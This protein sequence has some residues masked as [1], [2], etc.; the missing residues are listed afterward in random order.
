VTFHP[1]GPGWQQ[2]F[3]S[4]FG[5]VDGF[6]WPKGPGKLRGRREDAVLMPVSLSPFGSPSAAGAHGREEVHESERLRQT[7]DD[8]EAF[9]GEERGVLGKGRDDEHGDVPKPGGTLKDPQDFRAVHLGHAKVEHNEVGDHGAHEPQGLAAVSRRQDLVSDI[10][11]GVGPQ[12]T[13]GR[14]VI[15]DENRLRGGHKCSG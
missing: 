15:D 7:P 14:V 6:M 2:F 3:E 12:L 11:E 4:H 10:G 5:R 13:D 1:D 8:A 9:Y